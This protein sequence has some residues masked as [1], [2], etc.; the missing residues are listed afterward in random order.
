MQSSITY[1]NNLFTAICK[2]HGVNFVTGV[3]SLLYSSK[4][5]NRNSKNIQAQSAPEFPR[6][7]WATPTPASYDANGG[8][9]MYNVRIRFTK[10]ESYFLEDNPTLTPAEKYA[11]MELY[12]LKFWQSLWSSGLKSTI[13]FPTSVADIKTETWKEGGA[14]GMVYWESTIEFKIKHYYNC[15]TGLPIIQP[16]TA[17]PAEYVP[18]AATFADIPKDKDLLNPEHY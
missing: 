2:L 16:S 15:P 11:S 7:I 12:A 18:L 14:Q 9:V 6:A 17:L 10:P 13:T 3:E 4:I 1:I 5:F 8:T